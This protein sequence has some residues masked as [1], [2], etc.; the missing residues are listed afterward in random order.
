MKLCW[1]NCNEELES[2]RNEAAKHVVASNKR[3]CLELDEKARLERRVDELYEIILKAEDQNR[4][5]KNRRCRRRHA[6]RRRG[7]R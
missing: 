7:R 3:L 4:I 2:L 1:S 5:L 6:V